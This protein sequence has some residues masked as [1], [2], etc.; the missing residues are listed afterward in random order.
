MLV[1]SLQRHWTRGLA[2]L[3]CWVVGLGYVFPLYWTVI[4]ALKRDAEI[5]L[6]PPTWIPTAP[7][8]HNFPAATQ[9]IAFWRY[10]ANTVLVSGLTV[11]GTVLSCSLIAYGFSHIR[12]RGREIVFLAYLATIMLPTQVTMIPLYIIFRRFD[13]VGTYLPLILPAFFG[14]ALYVFL[15]RQFLL[16][17]PP[18]LSDAA[19]IDGAS[20]L[21]I[22]LRIMLPLLKPALATVALFAFVATYRDFLAPLIY[23]THQ[24]QWTI[25]LGLKMFQNMYGAQ[26][27]L[28]M[29]ASTLTMM[30]TIILFL[31]AQRT[32]IEGIALSGIKG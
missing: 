19:S 11:L 1:A 7:Q 14:N 29:A 9:Y 23:L 8:W 6:F 27:Q 22:F 2:Y 3:V 13:M 20:L 24:E 32:F 12:W 21:G 17:I 26:W 15:L 5:F 28:M 16:T 10:M 31:L 18:E 4:T 25:S 30:P